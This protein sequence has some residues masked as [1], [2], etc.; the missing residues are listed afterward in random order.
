MNKNKTTKRVDF[1]HK[2]RKRL[3]KGVLTF[4]RVLSKT[5]GPRGGT[6][7]VKRWAGLISTRDGATIA[8]DITLSDPIESMGCRVL[9]EACVAIEKKVGDGTTS[10]AILTAEIFQQA[11]KLIVGGMD[12]KQIS[13]GIQEASRACM[14]FLS[15]ISEPIQSEEQLEAVAKIAANGDSEI[16]KLLTDACMSVGNDGGISVEDGKGIESYL[17]FKDGVQVDAGMASA[18]FINETEKYVR[19]MNHPLVAV[20]AEPLWRVEDVQSVLEEGSQWPN[21]PTF[22]IAPKIEGDALA[23]IGMNDGHRGMLCCAMNGPGVMGKDRLEKLRDIAAAANATFVD[24]AAGYDFREFKAEWFGSFQTARVGYKKSLFVVFDSAQDSINARVAELK[25]QAEHAERKVEKE[26]IM[27]RVARITGGYCILNVGGFTEAEIK[28]KRSRVED[29]LFALRAA[30]K[31]GIVPG[32]GMAYWTAADFLEA[33]G[34]VQGDFG[35]GQ[36]VLSRALRKPFHVLV[37][38]S[39]SSPGGVRFKLNKARLANEGYDPWVG[40]DF[41]EENSRSLFD[42]PLVADPTQVAR[43]VIRAACSVATT[44]LMAEASV[45]RTS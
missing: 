40:W 16:G 32:G 19:H 42:E 20:I 39:G 11:Q 9:K 25:V 44:L 28:E 45:S 36:K 26:K 27:D 29:S 5:Y 33:N 4:S 1:G 41:N 13:A 6:V 23:T 3:L 15:N 38:N 14:G 17:V 34:F 7:M 2:M 18:V 31:F 37:E 43:E 22:V 12:P 30:M 21:N 8:R 24:P 35:E 10:V